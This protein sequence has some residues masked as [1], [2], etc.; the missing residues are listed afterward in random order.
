MRLKIFMLATAGVLCLASVSGCKKSELSLKEVNAQNLQVQDFKISTESN[1]EI[2]SYTFSIKHL[3]N[4]GQISNIRPL[5]YGADLSRTKLA[6]E[7]ASDAKV[8]VSIKPNEWLDWT[9]STVFDIPTGTRKFMIRISAPD[10]S[11]QYS[12]LVDL[13]EYQFDPQTIE[14]STIKTFPHNLLGKFYGKVIDHEGNSTIILGNDISGATVAYTINTDGIATMKVLAGMEPGET[15]S[16]IEQ[17]DQQVYAH[18]NTK[19]VYQLVGNNWQKIIT[20]G[21]KIVSLL[22][23]LQEGVGQFYKLALLIEDANKTKF[24]TYQNGTLT[25]YNGVV[26]EDFPSVASSEDIH[27]AYAETVEIIGPRLVMHAVTHTDD[28]NKTIR[29]TWYTTNGEDWMRMYTNLVTDTSVYSVSIAKLNNTLYRFESTSQGLHVYTSSDNGKSWQK[30]G[31]QA[32]LRLNP[33]LLVHR[34]IFAWGHDS[35][36]TIQMLVGV[37]ISGSGN[38]QIWRGVPKS[39]EY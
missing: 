35:S 11:A 3:A 1:M 15:I 22:G 6:I 10:G 17:T 20:G 23:V 21:T 25:I 27:T 5:P 9:S 13:K 16:H 37:D 7:V 38:A 19:K 31:D 18:T 24:A 26:P 39:N 30:N 12:Y 33:E 2:A 14:W 36:N 29:S 28:P 8:S 32:T 4:A 34:N